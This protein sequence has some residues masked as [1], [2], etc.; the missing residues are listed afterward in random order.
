MA[1]VL[2]LVDHV[3][4]EVKKVTYELLTAARR[5][6]E[7]S[8]VVVGEPGTAGKLTES[9]AA[10]GAAKVYAAESAEAGQFVVTPQV[11][12]LAHLV[13]SAGPAAVLV[14]ASID[15]KEIAGR[16][17]IRIGSGLLSEVVDVD[18]EGAALHSLFD[19]TFD[20]KAKV[21]TGT[22]VIT[23]LPGS[24]EPGQASGAAVVEQVEVP[25]A[26]GAKI[27]G[28]QPAEAGDRPELT[29]AFVVVSGGRGVGSAESF[30]VV[31]KLP[32]PW[33]RRW[34]PRVRRW[35]PGSTRT[36]SRSGRPV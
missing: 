30:E 22:Q 1:E 16:L 3:D 10:Y 11:H 13:D 6:G 23:V 35:T 4:G 18:A 32:T 33:V 27:T 5:M 19:G 17:A 25:A 26:S 29:E 31:E 24:I 36:S 8:A 2:V 15:G 28:R 20:A 14:P 21:I 9:L 12:V 7:P 34:L